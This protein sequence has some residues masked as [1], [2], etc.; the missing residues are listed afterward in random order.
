MN[1]VL[2]LFLL[3]EERLFSDLVYSFLTLKEQKLI[4]LFSNSEANYLFLGYFS[5][6]MQ[7]KGFMRSQFFYRWFWLSL[8]F[9]LAVASFLSN[10]T[11]ARVAYIPRYPLGP[12]Y[13]YD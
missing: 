10:L 6:I 5:L 12:S 1:C 2:K 3:F 4:I 11:E 7:I 8:S 13:R 9:S